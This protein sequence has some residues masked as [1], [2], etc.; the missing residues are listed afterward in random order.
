MG[1]PLAHSFRPRRRRLPAAYRRDEYAQGASQR[2]RMYALSIRRLHR[3]RI[4]A[5]RSGCWK[6]SVPATTCMAGESPMKRQLG[7]A[8][9]RSTSIAGLRRGPRSMQRGLG[10]GRPSSARAGA[11]AGGSGVCRRC[12]RARRLTKPADPRSGATLILIQILSTNTRRS[13]S[14]RR[15]NACR[16]ARFRATASR[17]IDRTLRLPP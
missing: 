10:S 6:I 15:L 12:G 8:N 3:S 13:G 7:V 11:H 17:A 14:S 16:R 1:P 5:A 4:S 2:I 9:R